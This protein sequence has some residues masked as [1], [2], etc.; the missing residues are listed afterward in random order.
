MTIYLLQ[1]TGP[2]RIPFGKFPSSPDIITIRHVS[3]GL[4]EDLQLQDP[5]SAD[6]SYEKEGA[7]F[8]RFLSYYIAGVKGH[9]S[10]SALG[11]GITSISGSTVCTR[12]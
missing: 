7:I 11:S 12:P 10:V 2:V 4:A 1:K 6:S 5:K 8:T 9:G 3:V